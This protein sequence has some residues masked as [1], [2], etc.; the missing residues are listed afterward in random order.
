MINLTIVIN[1]F[2][3][4][5]AM[6]GWRLGYVAAKGNLTKQILNVQQHGVT[7]AASFAQY[8]GIAALEGSQEIVNEMVI[9]V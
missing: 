5:Y 6:T 7:C 2:S 1:G 9:Y 4:A 8:A 3:K